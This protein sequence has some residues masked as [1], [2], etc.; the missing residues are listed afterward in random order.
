MT[1][2]TD[3]SGRNMR[4]RRQHLLERSDVRIERRARRSYVRSYVERD[5]FGRTIH[6]HR[7][8]GEASRG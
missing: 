5:L 2:R 8:D 6:E 3:P 1:R 4:L 7:P